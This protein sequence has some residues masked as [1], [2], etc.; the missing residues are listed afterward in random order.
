L[1]ITHDGGGYYEE[2]FIS[3]T[4][5]NFSSKPTLNLADDMEVFVFGAPG[6]PGDS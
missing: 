6:E 5:V 2:Y 1:I 3:K 4:A